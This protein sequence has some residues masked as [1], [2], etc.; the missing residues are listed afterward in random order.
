MLICP[1][2]ESAEYY[3]RVF[4]SVSRSVDCEILIHRIL[5]EHPPLIIFV[6]SILLFVKVLR[7][8][9]E[10][11]CMSSSRCRIDSGYA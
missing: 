5:H 3:I 11:N 4:P 10:L 6:V 8:F 2:K 7:D 1:E 9:Y